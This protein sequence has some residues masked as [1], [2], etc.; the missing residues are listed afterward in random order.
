MGMS[1]CWYR[2]RRI[3][4]LWLRP[5]LQGIII[6]KGRSLFLVQ[7]SQDRVSADRTLCCPLQRTRFIYFRKLMDIIVYRAGE[8]DVPVR[9]KGQSCRAEG[10]RKGEL[11]VC[12]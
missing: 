10:Q 3:F 6:K 8:Q 12:L 1:E 4:H 2:N 7:S 5:F 11:S 9:V